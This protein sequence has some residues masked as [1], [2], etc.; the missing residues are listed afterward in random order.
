MFVVYLIYLIVG[1][2][3]RVNLHELKKLRDRL[4]L[5]ERGQ[6]EINNESRILNHTYVHCNFETV[7]NPDLFAWLLTTMAVRVLEMIS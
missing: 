3:L 5:W 6:V 1:F 7:P 4:H 2:F